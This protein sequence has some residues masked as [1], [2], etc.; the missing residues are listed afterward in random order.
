M[1]Q[2]LFAHADA[3]AHAAETAVAETAEHASKGLP[4]GIDGKTLVF[5]F[6]TFLLVFIVLK[7]F[8]VKPIVALL[9]KRHKT[10]D[11]GVRMGLTMEKEKA[12]F[13]KNLEDVMREARHD[14]DKVI[15]NANKEAREIL[16]DAE[17]AAQRKADAMFADAEARIAE[18]SRQAKRTLEKDIV[19]MVS[20]ATEA[21]VGE[22]VDAQK[23]AKLID[24]ALKGQK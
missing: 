18:E 19:G 7:R 11:D 14:A 21:I 15:A 9:D 17:K 10:I 2:F 6:I 24:K 23:D 3:A 22:K 1:I 5:Q 13:D 8:A 4:L 20:E 12:K 16:R